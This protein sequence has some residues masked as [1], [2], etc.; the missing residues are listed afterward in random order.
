M[1][2]GHLKSILAV[3]YECRNST[4]AT[5]DASLSGPVEISTNPI[6]DTGTIQGEPTLVGK[7]VTTPP[8][9]KNKTTRL[10]GQFFIIFCVSIY[11]LLTCRSAKVEQGFRSLFE[12]VKRY[13]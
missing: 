11:Y 13:S 8:I 1:P 7:L 5:N 6:G 3:Y 12:K 2:F 4:D 10:V 9:G